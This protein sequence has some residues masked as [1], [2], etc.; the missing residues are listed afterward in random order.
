[1]KKKLF[2]LM[3]IP[4]VSFAEPIKPYWDKFYTHIKECVLEEIKS[5]KSYK[6]D[7]KIETKQE[8]RNY[9]KAVG[10]EHGF[11]VL[12]DTSEITSQDICFMRYLII[13]SGNKV[14]YLK[15]IEKLVVGA[16]TRKQDALKFKKD[17]SADF[18]LEKKQKSVLPIYQNSPIE[19]ET[20]S[21]EILGI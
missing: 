10:L 20:E 7:F 16:F 5:S 15:P 19:K 3:L 18:K 2:L 1:M 13:R 14:V 17:V 12:I 4:T 11:Y 9:L 21:V 8:L 6:Q